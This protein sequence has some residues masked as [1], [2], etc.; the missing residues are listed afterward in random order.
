MERRNKGKWTT[1]SE[2]QIAEEE[3]IEGHRLGVR[4]YEGAEEEETAANEAAD[5]R[6]EIVENSAD[7]QRSYIGPDRSNGEHEVQMDLD[8]DVAIR[9][10]GTCVLVGTLGLEDRF[11]G[12][13]TEDYAGRE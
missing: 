1:E 11:D 10:V 5:A 9:R 7:W 6:A 4:K 2:E 13:I 3:G 8:A 12:S